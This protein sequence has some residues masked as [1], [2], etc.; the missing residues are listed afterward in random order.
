LK[1]AEER[2]HKKS[3]EVE[4]SQSCLVAAVFGG[5]C[6]DLHATPKEMLSGTPTKMIWQEEASETFPERL[7]KDELKLAD[8]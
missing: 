6:V 3:Q 2:D 8:Q 7:G 1:E 5:G 4:R